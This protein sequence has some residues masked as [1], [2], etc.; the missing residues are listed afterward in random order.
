MAHPKG[1]PKGSEAPNRSFGPFFDGSPLRKPSLELS[2]KAFPY[3]KLGFGLFQKSLLYRKPSSGLSKYS[4]S[5]RKPSFGLAPG[6]LPHGRPNRAGPSG[7]QL[8]WHRQGRFGAR[9]QG[10]VAALVPTER[11]G[12]YFFLAIQF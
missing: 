9:A 2:Q 4:L 11:L 3:R 7:A 10:A 1:L 5:Y 8:V 6:G 12:G